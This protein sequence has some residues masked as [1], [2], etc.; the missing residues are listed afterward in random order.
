VVKSDE[1]MRPGVLV[2]PAAAILHLEDD[3]TTRFA[4]REDLHESGSPAGM[5]SRALTR[6]ISTCS[7]CAVCVI[8]AR[9][10]LDAE[11]DPRPDQTAEEALHVLHQRREV[12]DRQGD[13]LLAS[14]GQELSRQLPR[15]LRAVP[16]RGEVLL[17]MAGHHVLEQLERA[18]HRREQ[19]A[20][21]APD[22][23]RAARCLRRCARVSSSSRA[24]CSVMSRMAPDK[25]TPACPSEAPAARPASRRNPDHPPLVLEGLPSAP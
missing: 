8:R 18:E 23:Q 17:A 5:A 12:E 9:R 22:R 24:R 13:R 7:R 15:P 1:R 2:H 10:G 6:F 16:H 11:I 4:Y 21:V 20:E 25:R 19:V 3:L 14:E